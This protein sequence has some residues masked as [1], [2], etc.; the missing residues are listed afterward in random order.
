MTATKTPPRLQPALQERK[1]PLGVPFDVSNVSLYV[2]SD[3]RNGRYRTTDFNYQ[4]F[5]TIGVLACFQTPELA[6]RWRTE[7]PEKLQEVHFDEA[8]DLAKQEEVEAVLIID[9]MNDFGQPFGTIVFV[10]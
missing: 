4:D 5:G 1:A 6:D 7:D 2:L 3:D 8:L 10:A 9:W